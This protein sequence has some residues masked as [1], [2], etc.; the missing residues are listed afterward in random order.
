[1]QHAF[2]DI[3]V[4][5]NAIPI[6][7]KQLAR[8][9]KPA[10]ISTGAM[11]DPYLPIENR[12][13]L[14]HQALELVKKYG[15]GISLLTKSDRILADLPLIQDINQQT[16][17][18]VQVTLTTADDQ[19]CRQIEPHVSPTSERINILAQCQQLQIST[20]VWLGPILPFINDTEENLNF[21]LAACVTYGVQ[22]IMCFGFGVTLRTGSREFFYS[23]LDQKFPNMKQKYQQYYGNRYECP[24][25]NH[26][27][28]WQI[29]ADTCKKHNILYGVN[30]VFAYLAEFPETSPNVPD[31]EQLRLF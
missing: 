7:E 28:L 17:A 8:K 23:Q 2:E 30:D 14:T 25:P 10:M 12:L 3:E 21:L 15:F 9:R 19:L 22:A 13:K 29:L 6:L 20:V 31:N 27:R 16:K 5:E 18:V 1:M 24:S 26:Q 11:T 4:K